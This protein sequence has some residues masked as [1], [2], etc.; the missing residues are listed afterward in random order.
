MTIAE[1]VNVY[2]AMVLDLFAETPII[3]NSGAVN[4]DTNQL[5]FKDLGQSADILVPSALTVNDFDG[6]SPVT[7]QTPQLTKK[8]VTLDKLKDVTFEV[9][10][11]VMN[12]ANKFD[13]LRKFAQEAVKA[14]IADVETNIAL[15]YANAGTSIGDGSTGW[16]DDLVLQGR[17]IL[18]GNKAFEEGRFII[19]KDDTS[20]YKNG[21]I[22]AKDKIVVMENEQAK[23]IKDI[24]AYAGFTIFRSPYIQTVDSKN[25]DLVLQNNAILF[26]NRPLEKESSNT[27][28][29]SVLEK[30]GITMR[31]TY[32]Y[33]PDRKKK[34]LSTDI[35]YT[36]ATLEPSLL[37]EAQI[38]P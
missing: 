32:W 30:E 5:E 15:Q 2:N 33:D 34:V 26:V 35:L 12:A 8:S 10:S 3:V 21:L 28:E 24:P 23:A 6:T 19:C 11:Q 38:K 18:N 13:L 7:R 37:I 14:I 17:K 25:R 22:S 1:I 31:T 16:T 27:I 9:P 20:F 36:V 29:M 4:K